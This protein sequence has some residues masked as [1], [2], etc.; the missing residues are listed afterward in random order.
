[1]YV[2][3]NTEFIKFY[4]GKFNEIKFIREIQVFNHKYD[5]TP[6]F[7]WLSSFNFNFV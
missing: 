1:M 7:L 4:A 2:I 6:E 5:W 3:H